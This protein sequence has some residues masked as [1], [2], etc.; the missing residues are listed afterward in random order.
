VFCAAQ[1]QKQ[2]QDGATRRQVLG[3]AAA[4]VAAPLLMASAALARDIKDINIF[5]RRDSESLGRGLEFE[6][7]DCSCSLAPKLAST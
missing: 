6:G 7:I 5:E 3:G 1:P 4:L 2:Q